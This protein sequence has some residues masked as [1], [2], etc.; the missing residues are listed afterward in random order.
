MS[1]ETTHAE[2]VPNPDALRRLAATWAGLCR[3]A[4][5]AP[6]PIHVDTDTTRYAT[7][8]GPYDPYLQV[9]PDLVDAPEPVQR[10]VLGHQLGHLAHADL[11]RRARTDLVRRAN[12]VM[13]LV[14]FPFVALVTGPSIWHAAIVAVGLVAAAIGSSQLRVMEAVAD[15]YAAHELRVPLTL[16]VAAWLR[17]EPFPWPPRLR[18]AIRPLRLIASIWETEPDW[19]CR[20]AAFA[21]EDE[22]PRIREVTE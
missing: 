14:V 6:I 5:W 16:D 15:R 7:A 1:A 18:R 19:R 17:P 10:W 2:I 11:T 20:L 9:H 12:L 13:A 21:P 22:L 8:Y 4:G 3:T